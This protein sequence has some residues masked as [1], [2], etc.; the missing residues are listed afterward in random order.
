MPRRMVIASEAELLPA[1]CPAA[2]GSAGAEAL[3]EIEGWIR[4][5]RFLLREIVLRHPVNRKFDELECSELFG[6]QATLA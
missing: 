2:S 6:R 4:S 5:F 3:S 1:G